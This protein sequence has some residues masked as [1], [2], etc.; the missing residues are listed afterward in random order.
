MKSR[1]LTV[2]SLGLLTL[3]VNAKES[4]SKEIPHIQGEVLV[5]LKRGKMSSFMAQKSQLGIVA[6]KELKALSGDYVLIKSGNKSSVGLV[7]LLSNHPDIEYAEPNYIYKIVEDKTLNLNLTTAIQE[8]MTVNTPN[9]P[10]FGKLWGLVN[11]GTNEPTDEYGRNTRTNG[12][13]GADVSALAAWSL[14]KGSRNVVVAVIDTG[15]DYNHPDL[16]NNIWVNRNEVD[17]NGIDDDKNGYVDDY[18]GWNAESDHG[19]PMD[20]NDHG[21]HCS[22]TIGA[23]HNN[24]VGVAGVMDEVSIMGVKFLSNDG[25]G[26]LADAVEAIDYATKMNVDIM[27]NS[28]GGGGFSQALFDSITAAKNKGIIFVAAAGN[29]TNDNDAS[30]SYP[31]SYQIENVISVASHTFNEELSSFSS[32]GK[33]TVHVAAP[34]QNILST[35]PNNKYKVFSGTSMATPHVSGALGLLVAQ[36]GRMPLSAVKDRL[37]KT[38]TPVGAFRKKT[39][40]GGRLNAYN[41]LTNTRPT[42]TGPNDNAWV[43]VPLSEVIESAHP[44]LNNTRFSKTLSYPGAKYIKVVVESYDFESGYDYLS[45]KDGK[46][47]LVEKVTGRGSNYETDYVETDSLTLEFY[48]DNTEVRNGF[49]IKEVKVIY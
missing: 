6:K 28:W 42:R 8:K 26:T 24:G 5:K 20:G 38:S 12:V 46:G 25:S 21:T 7:N 15:V 47:S 11:N 14:N 43:S 31:A 29:S 4:F 17:G 22:G 32:Y 49:V 16:V 41:L 39:L 23:S 19:D 48:S 2:C 37:V 33:R 1:L 9:D 27:S 18:H 45:L 40:G 30:P 35:T 10:M 13:A 36:E 3:N 44:Y 34:G